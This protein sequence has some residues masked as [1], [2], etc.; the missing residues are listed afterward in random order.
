LPLFAF[1]LVLGVCLSVLCFTEPGVYLPEFAFHC[2]WTMF[3]LSSVSFSLGFMGLS[4]FHSIWTVFILLSRA[5]ECGWIWLAP[6]PSRVSLSALWLARGYS[7]ASLT[8]A[9]LLAPA[10]FRA[11]LLDSASLQSGGIWDELGVV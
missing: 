11:V 9:R 6:L 7:C 3:A 8:F 5:W 2:L 10:L 4:L 1:L